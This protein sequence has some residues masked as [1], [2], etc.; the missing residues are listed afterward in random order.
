MDVLGLVQYVL[1]H[2]DTA[3]SVGLQLVGVASVVAKLT[4][5]VA[6]DNILA[7]VVKVLN[8]LA[9]ARK[10]PAVAPKP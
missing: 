4:P 7:V 3:L 10:A 9:L 6:D 5:T 1:A 2:W 8:A